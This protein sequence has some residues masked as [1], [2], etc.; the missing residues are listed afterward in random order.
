M[1]LLLLL[2]LLLMLLSVLFDFFTTDAVFD[3]SNDAC[4]LICATVSATDAFTPQVN[5]AAW[6]GKFW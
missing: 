3:C 2:L 4:D 5:T 6:I 1:M